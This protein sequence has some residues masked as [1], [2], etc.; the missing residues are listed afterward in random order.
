[1]TLEELFQQ[2]SCGELANLAVAVEATGAI[3]K[4]QR[5]RIIGFANEALLRLHARLPLREVRETVTVT[6]Q[7]DLDHP[8][9]P[10]VLTVVSLMG[11][12]DGYEGRSIAFGTHPIPKTVWFGNGVLHLPREL[13]QWAGGSLRLQVVCRLRHPEFM[14][15]PPVTVPHDP[16]VPG[17]EAQEI[18]LIPSLH[19]ALTAY[20]AAK[21]Y[22]GMNSQ[23]ALVVAAGHRTRYEQ[24]VAETLAQGLVPTEMLPAGKFEARG[25]V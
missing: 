20:I 23:D 17:G 13:G 9:D 15:L 10:D 24:V 1:M 5:N 8:L 7:A 22:G 14:F 25:F 19:E 4:D 2:L 21:F 3:R 6:G 16:N 18:N 12:Q 11:D